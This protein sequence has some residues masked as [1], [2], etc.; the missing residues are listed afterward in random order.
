[1]VYEDH[2]SKLKSKKITLLKRRGKKEEKTEKPSKLKKIA[3]I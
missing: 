2:F 3:I 1:V